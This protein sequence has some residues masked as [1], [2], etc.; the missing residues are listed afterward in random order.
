MESFRKLKSFLVEVFEIIL[1]VTSDFSDEKIRNFILKKELVI[2]DLFWFSQAGRL[3]LPPLFRFP[4]HSLSLP[5]PL[6]C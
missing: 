4:R 6:F 5:L 2:F 1:W 3:L